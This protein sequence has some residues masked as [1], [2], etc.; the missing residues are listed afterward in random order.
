M[1]E[2]K[3]E[4]RLMDKNP[5][6]GRFVNVEI[7][8]EEDFDQMLYDEIAQAVSRMS[9]LDKLFGN[10]DNVTNQA[11]DNIREVFKARLKAN[12]N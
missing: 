7:Y 5:K 9:F 11:I 1:E 10:Y 6:T 12:K 2:N 4:I 3:M 8:N